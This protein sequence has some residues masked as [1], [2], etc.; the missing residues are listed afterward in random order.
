MNRLNIVKVYISVIAAALAILGG[1]GGDD[2]TGAPR[3]T[4]HGIGPG[5]EGFCLL[6]HGPGTGTDEF[7]PDHVGRTNDD[8]LTCH[9]G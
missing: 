7:P 4:E 8:C 9:H 1:C 3:I 5:Y 6:C 2:E